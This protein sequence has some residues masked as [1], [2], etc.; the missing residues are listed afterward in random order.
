[1][2]ILGS[3]DLDVTD[4]SLDSINI[5]GVAYPVKTPRVCDVSGPGASICECGSGPDGYSDLLLHFSQSDLIEALAL[6]S[7][8]EGAVV[9]VTVFGEQLS[10]GLEVQA[11]DCITIHH[12]GGH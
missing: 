5:N 11:T 4:I 3:A 10:D 12:P 2:A 8:P 1:M 9:E 7:E 6:D